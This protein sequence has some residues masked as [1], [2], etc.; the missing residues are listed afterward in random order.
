MAKI[1]ENKLAQQVV[2]M[3]G[4][5]QSLSIAQVKEV[6]SKTFKALAEYPMSE[7]VALVEKHS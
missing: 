2:E 3:E 5:E 7:V 1:N 4:G 6:I